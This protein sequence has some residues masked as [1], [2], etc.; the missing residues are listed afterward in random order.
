MSDK[1]NLLKSDKNAALKAGDRT[2]KDILTLIIND[3]TMIAKNDGSRDVT[4]ADVIQALNRTIKRANDARDL[5]IPRG[6]DTTMQDNEI[7]VA[8]SYLPAQIS[9][10]DL[11]QF[12]KGFIANTPNMNPKSIKGLLM[13]ALNAEMKGQFDPRN[14]TAVIDAYLKELV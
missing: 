7:E 11:L 6:A 12:V 13:K 9:D 14:A 2:R 5:M 10:A 4:D 3:A 8:R 1:L